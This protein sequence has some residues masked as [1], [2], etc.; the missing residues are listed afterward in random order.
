MITI[1]KMTLGAENN[2]VSIPV[3]VQL[4]RMAASY[5]A[6]ASAV[7][8]D[9]CLRT[10]YD[11]PPRESKWMHCTVQRDTRTARQYSWTSFITYWTAW[12]TLSY[13]TNA[14]SAGG[15]NDFKDDT[16]HYFVH[17]KFIFLSTNINI[18]QRGAT[19]IC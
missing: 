4:C 15:K 18:S 2:T 19:P 3:F 13:V 7:S 17:I 1:T 8:W 12:D 14:L 5:C 16:M 11:K 9:L 6:N 10:Y